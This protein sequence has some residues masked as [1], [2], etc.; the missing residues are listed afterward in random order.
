MLLRS[1][2]NDI[3]E[4]DTKINSEFQFLIGA[5]DDSLT[6]SDS[7]AMT[8]YLCSC[9]LTWQTWTVRNSTRHSE[10]AEKIVTA[11]TLE[12]TLYYNRL[13]KDTR[14]ELWVK[15]AGP[16]LCKGLTQIPLKLKGHI[17]TNATFNLRHLLLLT[18]T[19]IIDSLNTNRH[20]VSPGDTVNSLKPQTE[21]GLMHYTGVKWSYA[22]ACGTRT[23]EKKKTEELNV[24]VAFPLGLCVFHGMTG[25][26]KC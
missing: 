23:T 15:S 19:A 4:C 14:A 13:R 18:L 1:L 11:D 2:F 7:A 20:A 22:Y 8:C 10:Y 3:K 24:P 25:E 9:M 26:E 5:N 6:M 21:D 17:S 16:T 12:T